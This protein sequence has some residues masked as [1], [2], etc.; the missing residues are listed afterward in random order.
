[1]INWCVKKNPL[2]TFS[3]YVFERTLVGVLST[4]TVSGPWQR[5]LKGVSGRGGGSGG[6]ASPPHYTASSI[7]AP[8]GCLAN[9]ALVVHFGT[10]TNTNTHYTASSIQAP[11]GC[12]ANP[13]L[14]V[15]FGTHTPTPT[16]TTLLVASKHRSSALPT[17]RSRCILGH[18]HQHQHTLHYC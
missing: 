12:P 6:G 8:F 11:F 14:V 18:T 1:M 5:T 10:H 3:I 16:H 4:H 17:Q 2:H 7:Q 9:P 15:H 13:A